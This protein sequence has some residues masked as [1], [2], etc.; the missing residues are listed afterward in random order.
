MAQIAK[1][2]TLWEQNQITTQDDFFDKMALAIEKD[3]SFGAAERA[4]KIVYGI[5]EPL[6]QASQSKVLPESNIKVLVMLCRWL[7]RT[8]PEA[9]ELVKKTVFLLLEQFSR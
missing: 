9:S 1:L 7:T 4:L 6:H 8:Y 5:A 3:H 2:C